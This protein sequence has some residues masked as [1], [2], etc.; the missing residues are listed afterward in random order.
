MAFRPLIGPEPTLSGLV[1]SLTLSLT[2]NVKSI[3]IKLCL[4][5]MVEVSCFSTTTAD[6]INTAK[7]CRA[8]CDTRIK[9]TFKTT[10]CTNSKT[11]QH[12]L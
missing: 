9:L 7:P 10:L 12:R 6:A 2:P 8:A 3:G 11:K 4:W 5:R 1:T